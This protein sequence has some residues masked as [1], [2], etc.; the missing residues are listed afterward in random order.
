[1]HHYNSEYLNTSQEMFNESWLSEYSTLLRSTIWHM[2]S[3]EGIIGI[4]QSGYIEPNLGNRKYTYS[5]SKNSYGKLKN[6]VC[7]FDFYSVDD[8]EFIYT[9]DKWKG[10]FSCHKPFT[11]ALE[12]NHKF[13]ASDLIANYI[14]REEVGYKKVWIPYVEVWYPKPIPVFS[15]RKYFV[16]PTAY[17]KKEFIELTE[18]ELIEFANDYLQN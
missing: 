3:I 5:Q 2:T 1:M 16:I 6:Y 8:D 17:Q 9:F 15:I 14:A 18:S 13:L 10:F 4:H 12:L 7:L 11:I